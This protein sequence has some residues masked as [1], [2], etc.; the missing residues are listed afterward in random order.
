MY[1]ILPM[2]GF[3]QQTSDFGR[4]RCA[5]ITSMIDYKNVAKLLGSVI[6]IDPN[7]C[8]A[9]LYGYANFD[10]PVKIS[11][12]KRYVCQSWGYFVH[13]SVRETVQV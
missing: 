11:N 3:E 8:E 5:F 6:E 10:R 7:L 1:N 13:V 2:I 12:N 4:N 9:S